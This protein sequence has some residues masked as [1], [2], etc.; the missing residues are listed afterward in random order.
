MVDQIFHLSEAAKNFSDAFF[1]AASAL[2]LLAGTYA[3]LTKSKSKGT[4]K[5]K[6]KSK[7]HKH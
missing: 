7:K 5:K 6:K 1:Q 3:Q 2:A 4:S